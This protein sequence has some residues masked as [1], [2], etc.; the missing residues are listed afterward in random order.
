M[1]VDKALNDFFGDL[2]KKAAAQALNNPSVQIR[3]NRHEIRSLPF[4]SS[5]CSP[6]CSARRGRAAQDL[7]A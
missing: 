6:R 1:K 7:D 3:L 5:S 2:D 4:A